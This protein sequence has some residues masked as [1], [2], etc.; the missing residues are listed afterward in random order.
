MDCN[1]PNGLEVASVQLTRVACL[2]LPAGP[3][4]WEAVPALHS[5]ILV[6][7]LAWRDLHYQGR[8]YFD[9]ANSFLYQYHRGVTGTEAYCI[10][11]ENERIHSTECLYSFNP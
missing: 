5:I 4:L 7:E 3:F 6:F 2:S 9:K 8:V 11:M 1:G 10:S